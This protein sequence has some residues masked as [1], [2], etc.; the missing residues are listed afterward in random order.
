MIRLQHLVLLAVTILL[1]AGCGKGSSEDTV[2]MEEPEL[3]RYPVK[4]GIIE[5]EYTGDAVGTQKLI[6]DQWGY[7]EAREDHYTMKIQG[8]EN[9]INTLA[10]Q[11]NDVSYQIDLDKKEG[12]K[13][14]NP[15]P[16]M[17]KQIAEGLTEEQKKNLGEQMLIRMGGKKT[18]TEDFLGREC[19]TY[20]FMGST[21]YVWNGLSLKSL[22]NM[23]GVK[24]AITA[25]SVETDIDIPASAFEPPADV[26]IK[27]VSESGMPNPHG[28]PD[29]GGNEEGDAQN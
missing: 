2:K 13:M 19:T 29:Q 25:K 3:K 20:D 21:M 1:I 6:F 10:I 24:M 12:T 5:Y 22:V 11:A 9:T 4:S 18:G 28:A 7:Y 8:Q 17:I 27:D 26:K 23:M 15:V 16:D 14:K